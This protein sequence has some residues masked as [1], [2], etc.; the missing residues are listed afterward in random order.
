MAVIPERGCGGA[1]GGGRVP[2]G[3]IGERRFLARRAR[4][5]SGAASMIVVQIRRSAGGVVDLLDIH[6]GKAVNVDVAVGGG[7]AS[8][9]AGQEWFLGGSSG[10]PLYPG[11]VTLWP[12]GIDL[13]VRCL[14]HELPQI[15]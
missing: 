10:Q 4:Q 8:V 3:V 7:G 2:I 13:G 5:H 12:E 14:E 9:R 11:F 15:I 1:G 6:L